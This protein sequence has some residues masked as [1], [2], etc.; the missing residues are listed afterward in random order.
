MSMQDYE[1]AYK[2]GKKE[3]QQRL[4]EG[5]RPTLKVLDEILPSKGSY[6]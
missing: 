6:S 3:Y 2:L 5:K 4:M 1:K